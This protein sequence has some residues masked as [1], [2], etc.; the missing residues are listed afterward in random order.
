MFSLC[1]RHQETTLHQSRS[2]WS[3]HPLV[4]NI[5]GRSFH[6]SDTYCGSLS[7]HN[8]VGLNDE[9]MVPSLKLN[10]DLR[11]DCNLQESLPSGGCGKLLTG[12]LRSISTLW[13][14]FMFKSSKKHMQNKSQSPK[15]ILKSTNL[16]ED[17]PGL[18]T[19]P[20]SRLVLLQVW[21]WLR[22]VPHACSGP[23]EARSLPGS[24]PAF[25]A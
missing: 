25:Q 9:V 11:S 8:T 1:S 22:P 17:A 20:L 3:P 12:G 7:V 23:A 6:L 21:S 18:Q 2:L 5:T 19:C 10:S 13:T 14:F 16:Y 24:L 4:K 15:H